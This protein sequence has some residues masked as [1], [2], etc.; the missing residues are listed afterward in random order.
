M[1]VA[2]VLALT[3]FQTS[4]T[5]GGK[6][7][8][9]KSR[10]GSGSGGGGCSSN[11]SSGS[12]T[13]GYRDHD[14]DDYDDDSGYEGTSSGG[15]QE[16]TEEPEPTVASDGAYA[17]VVKCLGDDSRSAKKKRQGGKLRKPG[18]DKASEV[19]VHA[20]SGGRYRVGVGFVD[21]MDVGQDANDTTLTL[22]AGETRK[23]RIPMSD[24]SQAPKVQGC[25]VYEVTLLD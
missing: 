2:V 13:G 19:E 18:Y 15:A 10:S 6:S 4:S 16:P 14:N 12:S 20:V 21:V 9:G 8:S 3:G 5:S 17:V 11:K 24:S 1:L 25:E 23:V 7:G 22:K